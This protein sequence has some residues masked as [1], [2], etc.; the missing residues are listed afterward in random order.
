[1]RGTRGEVETTGAFDDPN[2]ASVWQVVAPRM[3]GLDRRHFTSLQIHLNNNG[4]EHTDQDDVPL[5]ALL[6]FGDFDGGAFRLR[7][8]DGPEMELS[9][10][11]HIFE[12]DGS[13]PHSVDAILTTPS[14]RRGPRRWSVVCH[15]RCHSAAEEAD[16]HARALDMANTIVW[17]KHWLPFCRA[18]GA[19][20]VLLQVETS[21]G[22]RQA[23]TWLLLTFCCWVVRR[24]EAGRG[25]GAE[26]ESAF[27]NYVSSRPAALC[28]ETGP[29]SVL[30]VTRPKVD[31][32]D[33][34]SSDDSPANTSAHTTTNHFRSF[35]SRQITFS[36]RR[37]GLFESRPRQITSSLPLARYAAEPPDVLSSRSATV[38][39]FLAEQAYVWNS[40]KSH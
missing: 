39:T 16:L 2:V 40:L 20:P 31:S 37:F 18:V 26:V 9:A 4:P 21:P 5:S 8:V 38:H 13:I 27:G 1:V 28:E 24:M 19:A 35:P 15:T 10:T 34:S 32:P 7:P 12:F 36:L 22:L 33:R 30:S 23:I 14:C 6:E 17:N 11:Q 25:R 3:T 29:C